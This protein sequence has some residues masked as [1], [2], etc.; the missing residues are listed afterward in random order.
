MAIQNS[1]QDWKVGS[2]VNVGFLRG[3]TVIRIDAIHDWRPD[4]YTL[5][6]DKGILYKFTPHYGIEK[7]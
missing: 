4:I 6:S 5:Q 3:L 1:K 2:K 7:L